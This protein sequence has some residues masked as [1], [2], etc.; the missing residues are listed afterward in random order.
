M[1]VSRIPNVEG[2]IQPTIVTAKGDLIAAV[3]NASPGRLGVGSDGAVLQADS[4]AATGLSWAGPSFT[5]GKNKIINGDFG[6]WQRGT[7]FTPAGAVGVNQYNADRFFSNRD[8]SGATVTTSRQAFTPGTAPVAGYEA[9]YFYRY[10]QTVAGTGGTYVTV[11]GQVIEGLGLSGQTVTYSFWA[12]ADTTRTVAVGWAQ[13]FGTGGSTTVYSSV[14]NVNLT[15]SWTRYSVTFAISSIAGKTIG[16]GQVGIE[17]YIAGTNNATQTYDFWGCQV[18]AG[19]VATA[20]QTATGTVQGE[21]AACQR[22]Y[23]RATSTAGYSPLGPTGTA[24]NTTTGTFIVQFPSQFR[25]A[26]HTIEWANLF[27]THFG[28]AGQPATTATFGNK[29]LNFCQV[30]VSGSSGLTAN[31]PCAVLDTGFN[32]GYLGYSAEL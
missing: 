32:T 21:L 9:Q 1:T 4:S 5:A 18:E 6:V 13:Y 27:L 31:R 22:Y 10:A 29:G 25:V 24:E 2:G 20:F 12:K 17:F 7:S 14:T 26:P 30:N 11:L 23:Y 28:V 15:T 3:A 8:G 19:S 16:T